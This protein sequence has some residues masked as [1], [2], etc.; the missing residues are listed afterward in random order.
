MVFQATRPPSA[1]RIAVRDRP[2]RRSGGRVLV[3]S[4]DGRDA[5]GPRGAEMPTSLIWHWSVP[6]LARS[7][8][9]A[10]L[11]ACGEGWGGVAGI[12]HREPVLDCAPS[13]ATVGGPSSGALGPIEERKVRRARSLVAGV[14][15]SGLRGR[16]DAPRKHRAICDGGPWSAY[17]RDRRIRTG[18]GTGQLR[19]ARK[20]LRAAAASPWRRPSA[21][22][23]G[24]R[25]R[26]GFRWITGASAHSA[27]AEV[28]TPPP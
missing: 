21:P 4:S 11:R 23:I 15:A 27:E 18:R 20:P 9:S 3:L 25:P 5:G 24:R 8:H 19:G 13:R 7:E 10:R 22:P 6:R 17:R 1:D 16:A 14:P 26:I 12:R 28:R 2:A